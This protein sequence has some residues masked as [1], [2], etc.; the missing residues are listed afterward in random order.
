MF[1]S[2]L[3]KL[4]N[5]ILTLQDK[6]G[7]NVEVIIIV[8]NSE[9]YKQ[10]IDVLTLNTA[11]AFKIKKL[12]QLPVQDIVHTI[13]Q[14]TLKTVPVKGKEPVK[15]ATLTSVLALFHNNSKEIMKILREVNLDEK[16][17]SARKEEL[18]EEE[19][20]GRVLNSSMA[21]VVTHA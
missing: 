12:T 6:S 21:Q 4:F 19:Y 5:N 15:G 7:E 3:T 9:F 8:K 18:Q 20:L 11:N 16:Y 17:K 13:E 14:R 1:L 2:E 10:Y